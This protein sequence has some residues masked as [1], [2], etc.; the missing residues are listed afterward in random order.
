MAHLAGQ[1][2]GTAIHYPIPLHLQPAYAGYGGGPGSL[3]VTEQACREIVSL[4]IFPELDSEDVEKV[5][6]AVND[7]R[8]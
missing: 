7:F 5:I 6:A 4:P 3:P 1:G 2:V 8:A